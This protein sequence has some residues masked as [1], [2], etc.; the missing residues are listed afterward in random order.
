[1][2]T[3]TAENGSDFQ[4]VIE[5]D[6]KV[7]TLPLPTSLPLVEMRRLIAVSSIEDE[8]ER[9][10][11]IIDAELELLSSYMGDKAYKLT[12]EQVRLI[13]EAWSD[14]GGAGLGE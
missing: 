7:Y 10:L 6:D 5:G 14:S 11:A 3:I 12:G 9:T 4:F 1:M 2:K 13:F 8:N